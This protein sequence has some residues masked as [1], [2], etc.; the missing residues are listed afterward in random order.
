MAEII[1]SYLNGQFT[2]M[3][4]QIDAYG[5][6]R[7]AEDLY[8]TQILTNHKTKLHLLSMYVRKK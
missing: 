5:S 1:N 2:Q 7:F 8:N 3:V 4:E 6:A